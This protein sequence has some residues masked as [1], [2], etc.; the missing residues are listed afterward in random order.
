MARCLTKERFRI[1]RRYNF[2]QMDKFLKS[3][4]MNAYE[5]G[6]RVGVDSVSGVDLNH[7]KEELFNVKGV[8]PKMK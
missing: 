5:D 8:G 6:I 1:I 2:D 4:Y 3:F 7:L